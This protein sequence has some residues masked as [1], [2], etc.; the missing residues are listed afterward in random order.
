M[1]GFSIIVAMDSERGIGKVNTLPWKLSG[2]M[3]HFK[4]ITVSPDPLKKNV[5]IMGR[6]TWE[7]LPEKFRPLPDRLNVVITR[8]EF[9]PLPQGVERCH[10]LDAALNKFCSKR[11][12]NEYCG[13]VFVIGGAQVFAEAIRSNQCKSLY[14]T[15]IKK[16]FSC[17]TFF[18]EIPSFFLESSSSKEAQE[19]PFSFYFSE[20]RRNP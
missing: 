18:P 5:V 14:I 12:G 20:Y 13:D 11:I 2:D 4:E 3:K 16:S 7:S 9:F 10:S 6:K 15:H 8:N 1:N 19:G 17:D